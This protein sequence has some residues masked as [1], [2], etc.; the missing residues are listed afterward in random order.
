MR[1]PLLMIIKSK[2]ENTG[3]PMVPFYKKYGITR[4]A[5]HQSLQ[6]LK[7]VNRQMMEI[8]SK[9][10]HYRIHQDRRA[11]SRSLYYNL[12][13]KELYNVGVNKFER[14]MSEHG[15]S[16]L[17]LRTKVVTTRSCYQSW[18]YDNLCNGLVVSNINQLVVGDLTY[19][20]IGKNRYYLFCLTDV[21]SYRIVGYC[22]SNR[23]RKQ[24]AVK[25]LEMFI[26]LRGCK[27]ILKCIHHTDGGSQYFS[28]AYLSKLGSLQVSVSENCLAN[29]Y[30]EQKNG[31]IKNHLIPTISLNNANQLQ[32]EMK[33]IMYFYNHDR[34]QEQLGWKSPCDF[35]QELENADKKYFL[36][37]YDYKNKIASKSK[38]F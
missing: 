1:I 31:Y 17:P 6:R 7:K 25:A 11:G 22:L 27:K 35:E 3:F 37:L 18:N 38:R 2:S 33:R 30:A 26:D 9:V 13:I 12:G 28:K 16:L 14:L 19:I 4:Q 20:S 23:M 10:D 34:K 5:Y 24:E 29:G 21:F 36:R 32:S 8:K 15:L